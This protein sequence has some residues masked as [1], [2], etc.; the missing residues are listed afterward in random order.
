MPS[1]RST[2]V[3]RDWPSATVI[4]PSL[5]TLS[6]ASASRLPTSKSWFAEQTATCSICLLD[7]TVVLMFLSSATIAS[8]AISMPF[9]TCIGLAPA[10]IFLSPSSKM[11]SARIVAVVVPSPATVEVFEATSLTIWAPIFSKGSSSSISLATVTPS[12]VTVG[13]PNDFSRMTT[14]PA[15]PSVTLTA[16]AS[17]FTPSRMAARASVPKAIFFAAMFCSLLKEIVDL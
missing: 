3:S 2:V 10:V 6:I 17:F 4:T 16:L 9:L 7:S 1:T 14:L 12:F 11:L 13:E 5:P 8:T 15:G